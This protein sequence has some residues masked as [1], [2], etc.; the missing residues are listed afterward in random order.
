MN[1]LMLRLGL[2]A[3]F[4][5]THIAGSLFA[6]TESSAR[7]VQVAPQETD[8][9]LANPGMGW[10]TFGRF[11]DEDPNL[12]GLPSGSAYFRFYW[13]QIE[14]QE[15]NIDFARFDE[16]LAHA[17]RAGQRLGLRIMCTGSGE[18]MDVPAWLRE[19]GCRGT[20]FT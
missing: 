4:V 13:R 18:F 2:A 14:P 1:T 20:E 19:Q 11:A 12:Q 6:A 3:G 9:L 7:L 17:L 10:Q 16:M 15:G 8:E 5:I